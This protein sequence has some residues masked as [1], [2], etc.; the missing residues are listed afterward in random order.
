MESPGQLPITSLAHRESPWP[1]SLDRWQTTRRLRGLV[2]SALA[3]GDS[4]IDKGSLS[5]HHYTSLVAA[6]FNSTAVIILSEAP[7]IGRSELAEEGAWEGG[8]E[9]AAMVDRDFLDH[10]GPFSFS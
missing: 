10:I 6:H 1:R 2:F 3:D 4:M 9:G 8:W 5:S 7:Q